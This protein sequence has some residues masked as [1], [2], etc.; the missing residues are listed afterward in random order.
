MFG[1]GMYFALDVLGLTE[2]AQI[3]AFATR[4]VACCV[5]YRTA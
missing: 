1:C 5:V 4:S 2:A 3:A